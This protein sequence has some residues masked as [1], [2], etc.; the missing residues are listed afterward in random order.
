MAYSLAIDTVTLDIFSTEYKQ[1]QNFYKTPATQ[2][3]ST[4]KNREQATLFLHR[5]RIQPCNCRP[6]SILK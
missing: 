4:W 2:I 1:N 5:Y 3:K 6:G